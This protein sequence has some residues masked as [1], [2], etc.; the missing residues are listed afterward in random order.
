M[1]LEPCRECGREVSTEA[2]TCPHCGVGRP[3]AT[4][5]VT[6][7]T[8]LATT[9]QGQV[10]PAVGCLGFLLLL[11]WAAGQGAH[12]QAPALAIAIRS[13]YRRLRDCL[14]S[15]VHVGMVRY[16]D[17]MKETLPAGNMYSS[18]AY[19]RSSF[20]HE[21]EL[22]AIK[23]QD[24]PAVNGAMNLYT[25]NPKLGV[26]V[27]VT[28]SGLIDAVFVAPTLP[29]WFAGTAEGLTRKY[30]LQVPV[31]RSAMDRTPMC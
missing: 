21:R 16:I 19:K 20:A 26:E 8:P 10:W 4:A 18:Y 12:N 3:A 6:P 24:P 17:F 15:D 2:Q 1:A 25:E 9:R 28:L 14:P 23:S 31:I 30:D 29:E 13:T 7:R 22:R 11:L 5:S 27:T